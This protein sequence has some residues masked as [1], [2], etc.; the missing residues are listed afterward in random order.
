[1]VTAPDVWTFPERIRVA[2]DVI[3]EVSQHRGMG[4]EH[5]GD[6]SYSAAELE[7]L[8]NTIETE[9]TAVNDLA[10]ELWESAAGEYKTRFM[11]D[12][13]AH[14]FPWSDASAEDHESY[15]RIARR[16]IDDGWAKG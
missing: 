2:A 13:S 5:S 8:A 12:G 15:R 4:D 1:M 3:R 11:N 7:R 9:E 16:L 10:F 14:P 6:V